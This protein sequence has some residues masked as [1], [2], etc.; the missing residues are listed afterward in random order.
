MPFDR[1]NVPTTIAAPGPAAGG[2]HGCPFCDMNRQPSPWR[3][4][5]GP[6]YGRCMPMNWMHRRLCSS[7]KWAKAMETY[8][9]WALEGV[10]LGPDVLEIGPGYGA[11]LRVLV[12]RVPRL[13]AVEIDADTARTLR[14]S[15]GDQARILH[16]DASAMSLPDGSFSSVVACTMLHHVPTPALQDRIFAEAFRVLRPGGVLAGSDSQP[17][18]GFR[19]LHIGDTMNTLDP[20]TLPDRLR[21]AGFTEVR[22]E[23]APE[24]QGRSIRFCGH[25]P[26]LS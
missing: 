3:A 2:G 6:A 14:E 12:R 1:V 26:A 5:S 25:K 24:E 22:V 10:D 16:E 15:W 20:G 17:S 11:N 23:H 21:A 8:L 9:P 19:L 7:D 4:R 18:L 13:T